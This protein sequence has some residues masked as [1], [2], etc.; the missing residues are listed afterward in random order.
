MDGVNKVILIDNLGKDPEMKYIASGAAVTTFS[1]A[2]NRTWKDDAGRKNDSV[3]WVNIVVWG[4]RAES[5]GQYLR[6]GRQVYVEG[7]IQTRSW[8][9]QDGK[10]QYRTEVVAHEVRFLGGG[11]GEGGGEQWESGGD[12]DIDVDDLPFS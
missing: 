8:D 1:L 11:R 7:R 9:G 2:I 12:G 10:K 4:N 3:E 5:C 6:Q